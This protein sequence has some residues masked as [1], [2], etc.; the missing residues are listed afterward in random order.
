MYRQSES[1]GRLG[2][3]LLLAAVLCLALLLALG[4]GV[5]RLLRAETVAPVHCVDAEALRQAELVNLNSAS[6]ERLLCLPGIGKV[7]AGRIVAYREEHGPFASVE[8]LKNVTGIGEGKLAA[9]REL[10]FVE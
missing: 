1:R 9:I 2:E 6:A 8:E 10:V 7:L 5:N 4:S 3:G